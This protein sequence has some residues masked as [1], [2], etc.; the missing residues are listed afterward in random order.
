MTIEEING[1]TDEQKELVTK[2]VQSE[3]DKVRTDYSGKLKTANDELAKYKPAEKSEQE[4]QFDE[5]LKALEAKEKEIA[6]KEAKAQVVTE[7][8][9]KG[10]PTTLADY[11]TSKEDVDK[12]SDILGQFMLG[13]NYT[14]SGEHQGTNTTITKEQFQKMSYMERANLYTQNPVLYNSLAN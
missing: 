13:Q 2:L 8:T 6:D 7:L 14:P 9:A 4:K 11:V 3:T 10:L 1:L 5:R 12:V